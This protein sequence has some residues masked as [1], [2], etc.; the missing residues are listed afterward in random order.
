ML[1]PVKFLLHYQQKQQGFL[2]LAFRKPFTREKEA[3]GHNRPPPPH[4]RPESKEQ[5]LGKK[6]MKKRDPGASLTPISLG[7]LFFTA[8]GRPPTAV[9]G[10]R[11][12]GV[13]SS[14]APTFCGVLQAPHP[15]LPFRGKDEGGRPCVRSW[16]GSARSGRRRRL[17]RRLA[18]QS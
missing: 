7:T 10:C 9:P 14:P 6:G 17:R 12:R 13:L 2:F 1:W 4:P 11:G 3:C 8:P 15:R 5:G 18:S 16:R